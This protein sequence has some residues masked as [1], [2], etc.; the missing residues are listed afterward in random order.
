M[1]CSTCCSNMQSLRGSWDRDAK[2][3]EKPWETEAGFAS[4]D[5]A[6]AGWCPR[7]ILSFGLSPKIC[8][9][10]YQRKTLIWVLLDAAPVYC[11]DSVAEVVSQDT[12]RLRRSRLHLTA[13]GQAWWQHPY[14][15]S[16]GSPSL[17][18]V[19]ASRKAFDLSLLNNLLTKIFE[20]FFRKWQDSF[21]SLY[22]FFIIPSVWC[23]HMFHH[24]GC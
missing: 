18:T 15:H 11:G 16:K 4:P 24:K 5:G 22:E 23:F 8:R 14:S 1:D 17:H 9:T 2:G 6:T 19:W 20:R 3:L 21:S 12:G 13:P 7:A 10:Q